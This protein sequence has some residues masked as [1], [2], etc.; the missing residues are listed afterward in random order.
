[1]GNHHQH[2]HHIPHTNRCLPFSNFGQN[3]IMFS[4]SELHGFQD[5]V[6]AGVVLPNYD[7]EDISKFSAL[8]VLTSANASKAANHL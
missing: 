7:V 5:Y 2:H 6:G 8:V 3:Q 1:M 4:H